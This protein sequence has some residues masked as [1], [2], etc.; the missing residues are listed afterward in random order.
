MR[1][2]QDGTFKLRN[3]IFYNFCQRAAAHPAETFV[4]LID[5]VNRTN[6][7]KVF[8]ELLMLIEADHRGEEC[9]LAYSGERFAVPA[10]LYIIGMMNTAD[11][12]LAL[13]DYALRRRF[14]FFKMRPAFDTP[15]FA[16]YAAGCQSDELARVV[17]GV[18]ALNTAIAADASL[19]EGFCIG[20]SYFCRPDLTEL[21]PEEVHEWLE[22]VIAYDVAPQLEEY[23]FDQP[24]KAAEEAARL[25][26]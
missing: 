10:N 17:A 14:G 18:R 19:G 20:H 24:E 12:S 9:T 7:S 21:S 13:M 6:V 22:S 16:A 15:G 4:F 3:G 25:R 26:G 2:T 11:R 1:P 8:G 5:E 23:W